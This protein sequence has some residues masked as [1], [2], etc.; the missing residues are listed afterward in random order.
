MKL[1]II[2]GDKSIAVSVS[3]LNDLKTICMSLINQFENWHKENALIMNVD[4]TEYILSALRSANDIT[5]DIRYN[6]TEGDRSC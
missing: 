4:K 5:F 2:V 6:N 1:I 3:D